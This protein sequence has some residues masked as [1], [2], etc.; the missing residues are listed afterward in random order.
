MN[1]DDQYDNPMSP[2]TGVLALVSVEVQ[3]HD[4]TSA[5]DDDTVTG[6]DDDDDGDDGDGVALNS[7]LLCAPPPSTALSPCISAAPPPSSAVTS[8][9]TCAFTTE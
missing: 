7:P 2:S 3:L 9:R 8:P 5:D 1:I 4:C 6:D